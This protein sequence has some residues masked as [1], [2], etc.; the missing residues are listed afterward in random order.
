M[1]AGLL[2]SSSP[3]EQEIYEAY[4]VV[5]PQIIE[6]ATG[7]PNSNFSLILFD[8]RKMARDPMFNKQLILK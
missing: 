5:N 6:L 3:S 7:K 1:A 4:K 8:Q 2:K